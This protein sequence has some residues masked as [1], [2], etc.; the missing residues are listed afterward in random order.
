MVHYRQFG[1]EVCNTS[2]TSSSLQLMLFVAWLSYRFL[3][4]VHAWNQNSGI[5][6]RCHNQFNILH[7][8]KLISFPGGGDT[9]TI[10]VLL[11]LLLL[12]ICTQNLTSFLLCVARWWRWLW[13]NG[14]WV[15]CQSINNVQCTHL[16]QISNIYVYLNLLMGVYS[17]TG[18]SQSDA[19]PKCL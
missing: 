16:C 1:L 13:L 10:Y 18:P 3:L 9:E 12:L 15:R 4:C 5:P 11:L 6:T 7:I 14:V 17:S 2:S 19:F 8:Y